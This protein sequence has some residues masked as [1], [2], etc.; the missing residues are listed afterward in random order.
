[1]SLNL[2][3]LFHIVKCRLEAWRYLPRSL[4]RVNLL[5]IKILPFLYFIHNCPIWVPQ[6]YFKRID[7][8]FSSLWPESHPRISIFTLQEQ[9]GQ[10]G[11]GLPELYKYV[12]AGQMEFAR[13]LLL[14]DDEDAATVLEA[15]IL[16]SYEG[17]FSI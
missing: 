3:P 14:R 9:P 15:A 17:L 10:G 4:T 5:Q 11:L 6:T 8:L 13:R 2:L 12:L 1:M 7:N 16:G